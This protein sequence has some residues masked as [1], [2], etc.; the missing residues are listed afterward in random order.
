MCPLC[1][2]LVIECSCLYWRLDIITKLRS[3]LET[4]TAGSDARERTHSETMMQ[5]WVQIRANTSKMLS[6][7]FYVVRLGPYVDNNNNAITVFLI[8]VGVSPW[9]I[10]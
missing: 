5:V 4:E 3:K 6:C 7:V 1:T 10:S 9:R 2:G 8:S